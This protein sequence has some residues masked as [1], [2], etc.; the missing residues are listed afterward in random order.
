MD[1]KDPGQGHPIMPEELWAEKGDKITALSP[2]HN[3]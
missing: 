2:L 3:D 1:K